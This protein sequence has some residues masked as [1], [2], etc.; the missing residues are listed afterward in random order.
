MHAFGPPVAGVVPAAHV[1]AE[2]SAERKESEDGR[3]EPDQVRPRGSW[4]MFGIDEGM[5]HRV[6][7]GDDNRFATGEGIEG[8][9]VDATKIAIFLFYFSY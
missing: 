5:D 1:C 7:P 6:M 9:V 3:V 8:A 4:V 2:S